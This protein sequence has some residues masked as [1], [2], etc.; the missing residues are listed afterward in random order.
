MKTPNKITLDEFRAAWHKYRDEQANEGP[1][2]LWRHNCGAVL[3][4]VTAFVSIHDSPF[5]GSCSGSGRVA[6]IEIP[7]CPYCEPKPLEFG[8]LHILQTIYHRL[9]ILDKTP[10]RHQSK[11]QH[12]AE[13]L[14]RVKDRYL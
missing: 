12:I 5:K 1:G 8:C 7:Y 4:T 9:E 13:T 6:R 3:R 2:G 10:T 11:M 14:K